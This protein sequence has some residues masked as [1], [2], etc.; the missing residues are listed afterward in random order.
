[1]GLVPAHRAKCLSSF[2]TPAGYVSG[3]HKN[4]RRLVIAQ[5]IQLSNIVLVNL[6][7]LTYPHVRVWVLLNPES[8]KPQ[9]A[10]NPMFG[11]NINKLTPNI[12][13]KSLSRI[14]ISMMVSSGLA[15]AHVQPCPRIKFSRIVV[16]LMAV[17]PSEAR[18]LGLGRPPARTRI[19]RFTRDDRQRV[20]D[21]SAR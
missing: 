6:L 8:C 1:M 16:P 3:T 13:L 5:S 21:D 20:K 19:P 10:S 12:G 9:T 4:L 15:G 18:N 7:R 2:R 14:S 17:I 11:A